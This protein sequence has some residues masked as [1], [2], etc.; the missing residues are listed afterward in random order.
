MAFISRLITKRISRLISRFDIPEIP[1]YMVD[2]IG[3]EA[4]ETTRSY[5]N[6]V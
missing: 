6:K 1:P 4:E 2:H 3:V 5:L